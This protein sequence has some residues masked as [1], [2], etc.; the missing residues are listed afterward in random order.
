MQLSIF[1]DELG[2]DI[3]KAVPVIKSWGLDTVDLRGRVYGRSFES[4]DAQ[5]LQDLKKLLD[6]YGM[7]VAFL[8][9]G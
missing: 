6:D 1:T 3:T 2:I 8:V 9:S 4:L 5:Q 7:K